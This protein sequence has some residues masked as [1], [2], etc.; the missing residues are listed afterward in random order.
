MAGFNAMN[1]VNKVMKES[2]RRGRVLCT[3]KLSTGQDDHA[4]MFLD[5]YFSQIEHVSKR[6]ETQKQEDIS[7]F[8]WFKEHVIHSKLDPSIGH[9]E[10]QKLSY[11]IAPNLNMHFLL[12]HDKPIFVRE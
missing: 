11:N 6:L 5:D 12:A 3:F 10:L 4:I 1:E 9:E 2:L 8:E 7:V